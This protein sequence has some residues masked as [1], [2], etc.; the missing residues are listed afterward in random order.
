MAPLTTPEYTDQRL[1]FAVARCYAV[2]TLDVVRGLDVR[3]RLSAE[4][5]VTFVDT[6]P[7]AAPTGLIAVGTDGAVGLIW[8][9]ND[10]EDLAGY[11][12]L[13]GVPPGE[14]LQALTPAPV[15]ENNYTDVTAEPGVVYVYA[16][17]AV[18]STTPSNI[19]PLSNQY[20]AVAR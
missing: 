13:R 7:P 15:P 5:C 2:S 18:D 11:L 4:T 8:Q 12:V 10:E 9:P 6:F 20:E 17:R 19:S 16:V 1:E 3:S 14:T